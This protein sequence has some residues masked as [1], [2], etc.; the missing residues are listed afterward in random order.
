VSPWPTT[1]RGTAEAQLA[2][3]ADA[4]LGT[5][6]ARLLELGAL[7]DDVAFTVVLP[8]A[9]AASVSTDGAR[10]LPGDAVAVTAS[11]WNDSGAP[12]QGTSLVYSGPTARTRASVD[13]APGETIPDAFTFT[14]PP[15]AAPGPRTLTLGWQ[16][17]CGAAPFRTATATFDVAP[18]P[19]AISAP[20]ADALVADATPTISG[21]ALPGATVAVTIDPTG[22]ALTSPP[23]TADG[24]GAWSWTVPDGSALAEGERFAT[25]R[26]TSGGVESDASSAVRF[27]VD[28]VPPAA[29][30]IASPA[31][32]T[33]TR[34]ADVAISGA[35]V[36]P[37]AVSVEILVDGA[38]VAT[39][40]VVAGA[41]S[42]TATLAD[43]LRDLTARALDAAG[44]ASAPS[45]A[46]SIA[47]DTLPP[48][49]PT[50]ALA[51]PS[52]T[53]DDPVPF[54]GDAEPLAHVDLLRAGAVVATV[55]AG[56]DGAFSAPVTLA[57]G[58]HA[59]VARA[60]D[61]AGNVGPESD[62]ALAVVDR[63][64][65]GVPAVT[66]PADGAVLGVGDLVSGQAV[67]S[68]TA[69][70]L[71][72]V[73]VEVDGVAA[74][75]AYADALG[76]WS[77]PATVAAGPHTVRAGATDAAGNASGPGTAVAFT[78]DVTVPA[79]PLLTSP[80]GP[81]ATNALD[82]LVAGTA[83]PGTTIRIFLDGV[84]VDEV[85]AD[86]FGA[87]STDVAL[88]ATDGATQ[89]TVVAVDP[90]GNGSAPTAAIPVRVDRSAPLAPAIATPAPGA[91]LGGSSVVVSG[92]A[93]PL[94]TVRV[95]ADTGETVE[96]AAAADG[97]YLATL[98]A[99]ADGAR[100]VTVR[101]TDAAGNFA[102]SSRGF[103][104]DTAAPAAPAIASPADGTTTAAAALPVSGAAPSDAVLVRI[105]DGGTV[106]ASG[107]PTAGTFS[108]PLTPAEGGHVY[109]AVAVDAA[110]NASAPSA[111]VSV[112]VDRAAPAAPAL[113]APASPTNAAQVTFSGTAEPGSTVE[114]VV[115]GAVVGT[116]TADP[117]T[118]AFAIP[119]A[120]AEGG[121]LAAA[122]A[123]DAAGN[124]GPAS[125]QIP[126]VV[127]RTGPVGPGLLSPFDGEL[128]GAADLVGSNVVV[129]GRT[130]PLAAVAVDV[131]GAVTHVAADA[132][133]DWSVPVALAD[134][135][136]VVR[137][138]ATDAAGNASLEQSAGFTLDAT[139]PPAPV[140]T[141][142][143]AGP[144]NAAT[145]Y[146]AGTAEPGSTVH[147]L[148]GGVEVGT[149]VADP[150]TGA[151]DATVALPGADGGA[152][153][154]AVAEDLAGNVSA[155]SSAVAV[156]VDRTAPA[157]PTIDA[158]AAGASFPPGEAEIRGHAE[159]GAEIAVT[160]AGETET[161]TAAGDG[162]WSVVVPVPAGPQT[163][164]V[165]AT[166]A[167]G[168]ASAAGTIDVTARTDDGAGGGGCGCRST[169]GATGPLA[170]L[171]LLA[172]APR[173]RR[174]R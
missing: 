115:A 18:L 77:V 38:A 79:T 112:T 162:T 158:P 116:G 11:V 117:T 20:A 130:E 165:T 69:E 156:A 24:A 76:D 82:L 154:S 114:I 144:T 28:T 54:T 13:A 127:D 80:A 106:V 100:T 140:L 48:A 133:G 17:A 119:V 53:K 39:V 173:R 101:S 159:P 27:V 75:S 102:E 14:L 139:A 22:A 60:T 92:T 12:L 148:V 98:V 88:P 170:L 174:V 47:V 65:P 125:A 110:G 128:V 31:T 58:S 138:T 43:G 67:F 107:A 8:G 85:T 103:T 5:W 2:L 37:E 172:L 86:A 41:F 99:V 68:G 63:T 124:T 136:H 57:E 52:P 23:V 118:G 34:V 45:P 19:P 30:A 35:A 123:R 40:P 131:D 137:A 46:V 89:L 121:H 134:G 29:P 90:A 168:N 111:A 104:V 51:V 152:A 74:G 149:A 141:A 6:T 120:L 167:A 135:P 96:V 3:A 164:S 87:F 33:T 61:A 72:F 4:A 113:A 155:A 49:K 42:H 166:D 169:G 78:V 150:T 146:V 151:F 26:Q 66:A 73:E 81:L 71:A 36:D 143:T 171:A 91:F 9:T 32:G 157:A 21:A 129:S 161:V 145:V 15:G 97:T 7:K 132:N 70:A 59:L 50:L 108:I 83:E 147:L 64:A 94:S 55:Q 153:V 1:A 16:L 122:R 105:L 126:V 93:E 56:A 163:V 44:N 160:V 109:T 142:P 95:T 84:L 62:P 25:A 10:Y